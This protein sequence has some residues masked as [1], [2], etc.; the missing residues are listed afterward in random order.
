MGIQQQVGAARVA[1][2][3]MLDALK[4]ERCTDQRQLAVA[5]TQFETAFLWAA[6]AA[7]GE[8]LLHG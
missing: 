5:R 3:A 1:V 4:A 7:G 6:N 8:A 2:Q